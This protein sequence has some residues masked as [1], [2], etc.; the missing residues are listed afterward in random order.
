VR[1]RREGGPIGVICLARQRIDPFTKKQI[2]L[3]CAQLQYRSRHVLQL[4]ANAQLPGPN[5]PACRVEV[6]GCTIYG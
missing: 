1:L 6:G 2:E 3:V 4:I 5:W